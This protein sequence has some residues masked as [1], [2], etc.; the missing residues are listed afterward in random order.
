M[1][2]KLPTGYE[3]HNPLN[4]SKVILFNINA[5]LKTQGFVI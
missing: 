1:G 2:C 5:Q 4:K 3:K